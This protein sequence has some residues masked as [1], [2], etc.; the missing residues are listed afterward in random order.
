ML[1]FLL[2]TGKYRF[3]KLPMGWMSSQD[4]LN[5]KTQCLLTGISGIRSLMD[6]F[7]IFLSSLNQ[8]YA[9]TLQLLLNAV[10]NGLVF[11]MRKFKIGTK[12]EFCGHDIE[13]NSDGKVILSPS[14]ERISALINFPSP[15]NK[16]EVKSLLDLL[17][18]FTKYLGNVSQL[19]HHIKEL[20]K[21]KNAF[22]WTSECEAEM[23]VIRKIAVQTLPLHPF[24][25]QHETRIYKDTSHQGLGF[26]LTQVDSGGTE[27][28][29][30]CRSCTAPQQCSTIQSWNSR[31]RPWCSL[32]GSAPPS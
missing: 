6:D 17:N 21:E 12:L 31:C 30:Q 26:S 32:S 29:G 18:T 28:F 15:Q 11:S 23:E 4:Y 1:T 20:N 3:L 24:C 9:K 25:I 8:A 2:P 5:E 27:Y 13:A 16:R 22:L 14:S 10:M 19:T 7:L